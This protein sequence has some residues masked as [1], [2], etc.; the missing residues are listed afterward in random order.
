MDFAYGSPLCGQEEYR[1][2]ILY[3]VSKGQRERLITKAL[4]ACLEIEQANVQIASKSLYCWHSISLQQALQ[5]GRKITEKCLLMADQCKGIG[6]I[7][8]L[9][10]NCEAST[11]F[12]E[13]VVVFHQHS[14]TISSSFLPMR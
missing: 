2:P 10:L 8:S 6:N 9:P 1:P 5:R 12:C 4:I 7:K 13:I 14:E 3:K 11:C